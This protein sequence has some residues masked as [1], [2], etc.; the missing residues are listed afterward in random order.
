[1]ASYQFEMGSR[2][3]VR[4]ELAADYMAL[5]EAAHTESGGAASTGHD[6]VDLAVNART[7][8]QATARA[9]LVF[10]ASF[11][12]TI[13]WRPELTVGW[14][15]VVSGG[16]G[17]TTAHFVGGAGTPFS[18]SPNFQD[19]GGI[20]ARLGLRAGGSYADFS[21]D[22]GGQFRNSYQTYDARAVARFLF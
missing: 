4:P 2:F 10:G 1:M 17:V 20:L 21:A 11:G 7:S 15:D 9:D 8:T 14:R 16:P 13:R 12:T 6:A 18:L 3:Y 5:F 22:A 19:K